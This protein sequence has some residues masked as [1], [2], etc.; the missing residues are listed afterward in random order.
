MYDNCETEWSQLLDDA[1]DWLPP[2]IHHEIL[3]I[4]KSSH[5]SDPIESSAFLK[6]ILSIKEADLDMAM[7]LIE[8]TYE[9]TSYPGSLFLLRARVHFLRGEYEQLTRC[10]EA[11]STFDEDKEQLVATTTELNMLLKKVIES[12]QLE[13]DGVLDLRVGQNQELVETSLYNSGVQQNEA[14]DKVYHSEYKRNASESRLVNRNFRFRQFNSCDVGR[15]CVG[16]RSHDQFP[17]LENTAI[18]VSTVSGS[19]LPVLMQ[20]LAAYEPGIAIILGSKA[21]WDPHKHPKLKVNN[22]YSGASN[23]GDAYNSLIRIAVANKYDYVIV[24]NDDV[25]VDPTSIKLLLDDYIDLRGSMSSSSIGYLTARTNFSRGVQNIRVNNGGSAM[26]GVKFESESEV[27][28]TPVISPIFSLVK[29]SNWLPFPPINWFSDDLQCFD[30]RQRGQS[31]FVSRSYVH[32]V[33]S[34]T[35]GLDAEKNVSEAMPWLRA[36]RPDFLEYL[37]IRSI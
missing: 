32:H 11:A 30:M 26:R 17:S 14:A 20:S 19:S 13:S 5:W 18:A 21:P 37:R 7:D 6:I 1:I 27:L 16:S 12:S 8:R 33:G 2:P 3:T 15:M 24:C 23:F 22:V 31:H 29:L 36:N 25:V 35:V 9:T 4:E 34:Q 10:L 28:E